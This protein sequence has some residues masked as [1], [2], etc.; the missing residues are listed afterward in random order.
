M[1]KDEDNADPTV[2]LNTMQDATQYDRHQRDLEVSTHPECWGLPTIEKES[3]VDSTIYT[4][5]TN[6]NTS[7]NANLAV[8]SVGH[9]T[10]LPVIHMASRD[11]QE[12]F[13]DTRSRGSAMRT[14][15]FPPST[16]RSDRKRTF[17]GECDSVRPLECKTNNLQG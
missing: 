2:F 5:L 17:S 13:L 1:H 14:F 4:I 16:N 8:S 6:P 3:Y 11:I 9:E 12:Y 10:F 7:Q 15:Q